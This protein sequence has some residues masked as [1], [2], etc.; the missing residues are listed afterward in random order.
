MLNNFRAFPFPPLPHPPLTTPLSGITSR[1]IFFPAPLSSLE[2]PGSRGRPPLRAQLKVPKN[3]SP[4]LS[5]PPPLLPHLT[6]TL[7]SLDPPG[8][9]LHHSHH[10]AHLSPSPSYAPPPSP[11]PLTLIR[12]KMQGLVQTIVS[13][14][15]T[16]NIRPAKTPDSWGS[17]RKVRG[18][19]H[20]W[21]WFSLACAALL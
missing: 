12:L 19:G 4:S 6:S 20:K 8:P 13:L 2:P 9:F 11:P 21:L 10:P 1:P 14:L 17:F 3:I 16:N 7:F 5:T 15:Q 18:F